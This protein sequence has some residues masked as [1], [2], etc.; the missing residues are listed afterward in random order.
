MQ[1]DVFADHGPVAT[2][3]IWKVMAIGRGPGREKSFGD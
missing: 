1:A 3:R 2:A